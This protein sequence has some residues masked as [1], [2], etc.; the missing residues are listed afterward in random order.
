MNLNIHIMHTDIQVAK[1]MC[2]Y[3]AGAIEQTDAPIKVLLP[4]RA[5]TL[6]S[7]I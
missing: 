7:D 6:N 4:T 1:H 3:P 5:G 2:L